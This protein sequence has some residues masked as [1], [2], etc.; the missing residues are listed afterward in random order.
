MTLKIYKVTR[1]LRLIY[2]TDL[3]LIHNFCENK[4][5]FVQNIAVCVWLYSITVLI[6]EYMISKPSSIA[7]F[8]FLK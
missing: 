5:F 3:K 8:L 2:C 1:L 6:W 7:A 4:K